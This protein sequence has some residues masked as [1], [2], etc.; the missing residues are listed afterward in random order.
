[1]I[2]FQGTMN[3]MVRKPQC[4]DLLGNTQH[5]EQHI[6]QQMKQHSVPGLAIAIIY[7][8]EL[9]YANGFGVTSIEDDN[10]VSV[11]P[12]TLF[13]VASVTKPM[14]GT[15]IMHLIDHGL[16]DLDAYVLDYL[17]WF[18]LSD[19]ESAKLITLRMLMSHTSG[20]PHDHKPFGRSE[21]DALRERVR[22]E[23]PQ[24]ALIGNPGERFSYSN[25]GIHI[26]AHIAEVVTGQYYADIMQSDILNPLHM[27]RTTFDPTIA[28][29]Y[30]IAQSHH[31]N[32]DGSMIVEHRMA[33]NS[34]NNASGQI[35]SSVSDLVN[36]A[37]LHLNYGKF[38]DK[39]II[40]QDLIHEMHRA[41]VIIDSDMQRYYG[42]TFFVDKFMGVNKVS[43]SGGM[44]NYR[45]R[46]DLLP[47]HQTAV[48]IA[49]NRLTDDF[50]AMQMIN[51]IFEKVLTED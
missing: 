16:L 38:M 32:D 27:D 21:P 25:S 11:T 17:P 31:M 29:T 10:Q 26:L 34:A 47:S 41:N 48:I 30:P 9:V 43:H 51:D 46:F 23:I 28:M 18:S 12:G 15:M 35:Y 5:W 1:M 42:L 39:Q 2:L 50:P 6:V 40:R 33:Q 7:R 36:F 4:D 14:T 8:N 22:T 37:R 19:Q 44:N 20:L 24:Y 13:R 3:T 49:Y 45:T